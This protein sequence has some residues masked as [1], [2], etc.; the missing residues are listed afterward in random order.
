M[1]P[2][3]KTY[4]ITTTALTAGLMAVNGAYAQ[5][6]TTA[7]AAAASATA[8]TTTTAIAA[9]ATAKHRP[10]LENMQQPVRH[11]AA[12]TVDGDADKSDA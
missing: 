2:S 7:A 9:T 6:A 11:R 8:A 5:T 3:F 10:P 1:R 4:W 12:P